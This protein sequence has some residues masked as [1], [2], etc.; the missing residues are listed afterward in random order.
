MKPGSLNPKYYSIM[1]IFDTGQGDKEKE[2]PGNIW[3]W[4]FS[5]ISLGIIVV[6]SIL[7][8]YKYSTLDQPP[9]ILKDQST[10]QSDSIDRQ[11][12]VK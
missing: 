3:G 9:P 6:L 2:Y 4:K 8:I 1:N 10:L 5:F 7:A 12:P 11:L